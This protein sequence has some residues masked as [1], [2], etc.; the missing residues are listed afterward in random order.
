MPGVAL[1][2]GAGGT[3][4]QAWHAGVLDALHA[5]LG[6]DARRADLVVGTSAGSVAGALL[7]A[8]ISA[9]DLYARVTDG[10]LSAEGREA[11][12]RAGSGPRPPTMPPPRTRAGGGR[13]PASMGLLARSALQPWRLRPGLFLAGAL[14][15]GEVDA[16]MIERGIGGLHP[17]GWPAAPFYVNAVRLDDGVRVV[18]GRPGSPAVGVGPAVDASCAIPGYFTPVTIQ[19]REYVDGGVHSP[20]NADLA[21]GSSLVVVSSPMSIDASALRRP[22]AESVLRIAHR[23]SLQRELVG[24]RR[25]GTPVVTFQPGP[26]DLAVRGGT[27]GSMDARRREP[28][29]RRARETTVRRLRSDRL[30][31]ALAALA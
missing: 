4:G 17:D 2:L 29:A 18:F 22:G 25:R 13:R 31:E 10:T 27:A 21:G 16:A 28:V 15:R 30:R 12:R 3:V 23:A 1:V 19:G 7:R 6:W 9:A 5:E 11:F 20:T 24:L 14:P 8:G 26:D